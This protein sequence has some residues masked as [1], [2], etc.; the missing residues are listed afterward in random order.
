VE[1]DKR[2]HRRFYPDNFLASITL[3]L[4][5]SPKKKI[6]IEGTVVDMSYTGIKIKLDSPIDEDIQEAEIHINLMMP[7]SGVP[8]TIKGTIK[9]LQNKSEY[10]LQYS[11]KDLGLDIDHLM[12]ECIKEVAISEKSSQE[13][14]P[15]KN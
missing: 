13:I 11:E 9:H 4:E 3:I 14:E 10:G 8:I 7:E 12:F 15:L 1:T 5:S 6:K 2:K